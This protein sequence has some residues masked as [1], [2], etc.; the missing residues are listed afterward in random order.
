MT[1]NYVFCHTQL[2]GRGGFTKPARLTGKASNPSN[3][4]YKETRLFVNHNKL[5]TIN[6]KLNKPLSQS[7]LIVVKLIK[8]GL[9][10]VHQY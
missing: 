10:F 8:I 2:G 3:L 9:H 5:Q 1:G 7:R 6:K 4:H